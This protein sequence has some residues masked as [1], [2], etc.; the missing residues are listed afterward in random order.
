MRVDKHRHWGADDVIFPPASTGINVPILGSSDGSRLMIPYKTTVFR[1]RSTHEL[2][3][4]VIVLLPGVFAKNLYRI[5]KDSV[6][7]GKISPVAVANSLIGI[8][9]NDK[10]PV[11][12]RNKLNSS[13]PFIRMRSEFFRTKPNFGEVYRNV[14]RPKKAGI[15]YEIKDRGTALNSI[16][17]RALN[18]ML[19]RPIY[20]DPLNHLLTS[21]NLL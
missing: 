16:S 1:G 12:L 21:I 19:W 20:L 18:Y 6:T 7:T 5:I 15:R 3:D 4:Q 13:G 8:G 9:K 2:G 10:I 17:F 11:K 14:P